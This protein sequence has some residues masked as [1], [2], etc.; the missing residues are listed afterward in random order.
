MYFN[1]KSMNPGGEVRTSRTSFPRLGS[2]MMRKFIED[3][4]DVTRE[5]NGI[6]FPPFFGRNV[7][8][9][10]RHRNRPPLVLQLIRILPLPQWSEIPFPIWKT[11]KTQQQLLPRLRNVL[12]AS[13]ESSDD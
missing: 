7:E 6:L 4:V 1:R 11:Q 13:L 3:S 12:D 8:K 2:W 9:V 5:G 10:S